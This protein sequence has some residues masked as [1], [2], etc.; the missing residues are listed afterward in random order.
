M[1]PVAVFELM[2]FALAYSAFCRAVH[3]D[4]AILLRVRVAITGIAG[5]AFYGMYKPVTGWVPDELHFALVGAAWWYMVAFA[6]AW[7]AVRQVEAL[8]KPSAGGA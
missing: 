6:K 4:G 1:I 2:C 5:A 8:R 7:P 3:V